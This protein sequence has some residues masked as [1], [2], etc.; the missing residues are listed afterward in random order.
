VLLLRTLLGLDPDPAS[1]TLRATAAPL[2]EWAEGLALSGVHAFGRR[3][4]VRVSNGVAA[5][6][7]SG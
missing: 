6:T 7:S 4:D 5:V 3:F 1:R 2:P